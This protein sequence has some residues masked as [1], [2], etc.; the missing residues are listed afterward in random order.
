MRISADEKVGIGR[1]PSTNLLEVE[2]TASKTTAGTWLA[3]S[4]IGIKTDIQDIG[5]ALKVVNELHPVKFR[6][7][8]EYRAKHPSIEDR[9]YYNFI[10]QEFQKVFPDSVQEG[11]DGYLQMDA[12]NVTPYLVAAVQELS[13]RNEELE[14]QVAALKQQNAELEE[15]VAALE[16]L[17]TSLVQAQTE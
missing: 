3:N 10:A 1:N 12:Y 6:Y 8:D 2:G 17:V 7:T 4:D 11:W 16:A 13:E 14:E 5:D 9:T 15:R